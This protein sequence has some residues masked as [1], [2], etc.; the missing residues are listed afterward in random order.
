MRR[1][2]IFCGGEVDTDS[3]WKEEYNND[4]VIC[5]DGGLRHAQRLGIVPDMVIGDLDSGV[6]KYPDSIQHKI[7]PSEKDKTDTNLCLDYIIENGYDEVVILGGLGGRL[8]HE[9]SNYCLL[10]YGLENGVRVRLINGQNEIWVEDRPFTIYPSDMKYI[11]FF[12]FGGNVNGFT[13]KGLKYETENVSLRCDLAQASSN[14][15]DGEKEAKVSFEKGG[16]L[17]VM[18]SHDS[19]V[20]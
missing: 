5:A 17:L 3:V 6:E 15:F 18:R 7:Y 11:S 4:F 12:P 8:D 9:F 1:A 14:Q 19:T 13:V 20:L 16:I 10:L 2:I